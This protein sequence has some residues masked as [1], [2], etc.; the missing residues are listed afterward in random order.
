QVRVGVANTENDL[1]AP[2]CVQLAAC[3]IADIVANRRKR[4]RRRAR[5]RDWHPSTRVLVCSVGAGPWH[6][7]HSRPHSPLPVPIDAR[8]AELLIELEMFRE[9]IH[10]LSP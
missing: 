4:F 8:Y 2:E 1:R 7:R 6:P 9:R 10:A 5:N 3:A